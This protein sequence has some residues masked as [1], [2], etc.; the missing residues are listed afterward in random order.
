M[1]KRAEEVGTGDE[2]VAGQDEQLDA[3]GVEQAGEVVV[4]GDAPGLAYG[5][6]VGEPA[7]LE[8][9]APGAPGAPARGARQSGGG[10]AQV[11][12][13]GRER[14]RFRAVRR[15]RGRRRPRS[16]SASR[17]RRCRARRTTSA[18]SVARG[19]VAA[20]RQPADPH[21]S[22]PCGGR[23]CRLRVATF[24]GHAFAPG[25]RVGVGAAPEA[26][27]AARGPPRPRAARRPRD[28]RPSSRPPMKPAAKRSPA[29]VTST[30]SAGCGGT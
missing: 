18:S 21:G 16:R 5:G 4:K 23:S 6:L 27:D 12:E 19:R 7:V 1:G 30:T 22:R 26:A 2:H 9:V 28:R 20:A 3:V 13:Q 24:F 25:R 8:D 14:R 17:G 10:Q 15:V 29:P 11:G